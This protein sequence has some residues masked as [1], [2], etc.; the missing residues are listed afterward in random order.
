M[1]D[2]VPEAQEG[3]GTTGSADDAPLRTAREL[4]DALSPIVTD[5]TVIVCVGNSLVGDDGAGV[6]VAERLAGAVPWRVFDAQTVPESFLMKI[7]ELRPDSLVLVDALE[8]DA[9]PGTLR[10]LGSR[11]IAGQSPS[12]HG[13]APVLFLDLVNRLHPCRRVVLGIQPKA[14]VFGT[15]LSAPVS[16]AVDTV[17]EA[18]HLL[19]AGRTGG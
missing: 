15:G 5:S 18:F 6:A 14:G 4:A 19:A 8:M 11:R 16:A 13:P 10:L 1:A 2:D 17:V 12:T 7:V 3:P 9:S